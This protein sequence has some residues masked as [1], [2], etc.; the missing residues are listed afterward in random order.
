VRGAAKDG[1]SGE[2]FW[3]TPGS[4]LWDPA[5]WAIFVAMSRR[6]AIV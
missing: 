4:G 1:Q 2:Q 6:I 3:Q 5:R